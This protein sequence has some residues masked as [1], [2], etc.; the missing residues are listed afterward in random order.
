MF[1]TILRKLK[2]M[3]CRKKTKAKKK[4]KKKTTPKTNKQTNLKK[5]FIH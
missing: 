5:I 3:L 1:M 4:P 2:E